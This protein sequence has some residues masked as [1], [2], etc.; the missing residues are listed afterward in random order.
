MDWN[1]IHRTLFAAPWVAP[2]I[3]LN[4]TQPIDPADRVDLTAHRL[5]VI[6]P[7]G[8]E[9]RDDGFMLVPVSPTH[10]TLYVHVADVTSFVQTLEQLE[11]LIAKGQTMYRTQHP[12]HHLLSHDAVNEITLGQGRKVRALSVRSTWALLDG[13]PMHRLVDTPTLMWTW[14]GGPDDRLLTYEEAAEAF[15][16]GDAVLHTASAIADAMNAARPKPAVEFPPVALPTIDHDAASK[17]QLVMDSASTRRMKQLIAEMAIFVNHHVCAH[18]HAQQI[19]WR[20]ACRIDPTTSSSSSSSVNVTS[21]SAS[22]CAAAEA[23]EALSLREYTHATSPM[24]RA[25]DCVAH[26]LLRTSSAENSH[27]PHLSR[28]TFTDDRLTQWAAQLSSLSK[29]MRVM[30]QCDLKFRYL[31]WMN[32]E[33]TAGRPVRMQVEYTVP[34]DTAAPCV[35]WVNQLNEHPVRF[36]YLV[37]HARQTPHD[38]G[39]GSVSITRVRCPRKSDGHGSLPELEE[40]VRRDSAA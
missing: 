24:R 21:L 29:S 20:R 33:T 30:S 17:V 38:V 15:A 26:L 34:V 14:V 8:A 28:A 25:S 18:L 9:D 39:G 1:R 22:Y 35:V 10:V 19:E 37:R 4:L 32:Q 12:P 11:A 6:D 3:A 5:W 13:E 7:K 16:A 2:S 36:T 23:H 40:F 27:G 31:Q